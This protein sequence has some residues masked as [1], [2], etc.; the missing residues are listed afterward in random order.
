MLH[1]HESHPFE[2]IDL[3]SLF[4]RYYGRENII[5]IHFAECSLFVAYLLKLETTNKLKSSGSPYS[6]DAL[7]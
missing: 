3:L 5:C 1:V 6:R 4:T 7:N 2:I